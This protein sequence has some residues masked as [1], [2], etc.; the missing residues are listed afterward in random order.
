MS[1]ARHTRPPQT[2]STVART[3]CLRVVS[4]TD[5]GVAVLAAAGPDGAG[6]AQVSNG[7][8]ARSLRRFT[9]AASW[10]LPVYGL[11]LGLSTVGEVRPGGPASYVAHQ[12][13]MR[14][15]GW[16]LALCA[17][18]I[19]LL[20]VAGLHAA[21]SARRFAA[22]GLVAGV[23][24]A[25][26]MLPFAMLPR[27]MTVG[28]LPVEAP[29]LFGA[30]LY[31]LGWLLVGW[32]ALRSRILSAVDAVLLMVAAPML[33][34]V[35]LLV[36]PLPTVG[37]LLV[38]AAGIGAVRVARQLVP[39]PPAPSVPIGGDGSRLTPYARVTT[40]GPAALG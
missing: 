17:G 7:G 34:I 33:G 37:A 32:A 20:A 24:G 28:W 8:W 29:K 26:L 22:W 38:L 21:S 3:T 39:P 13:P 19:A 36:G 5:A 16:A 14:L 11:L 9:R 31:S 6:G 25:G 27:N 4:R 12:Q 10:L 35:G 40:H 30:T 23:V 15:I 1:Q 2:A 18:L